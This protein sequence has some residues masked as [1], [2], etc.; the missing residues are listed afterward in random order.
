ME[1][2]HQLELVGEQ[3]QQVPDGPVYR[4]PGYPCSSA[5]TPDT[6]A[7]VPLD[8]ASQ[9]SKDRGGE[10]V[11][12]TP[13]LPTLQAARFLEGPGPTTDAV[14]LWHSTS[15]PLADQGAACCSGRAGLPKQL[16]RSDAQ[17]QRPCHRFNIIEG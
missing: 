1:P 17:L 8:G 16:H 11:R 12:L 7:G 5:E 6:K 10:A 3:A 4:R 15:A 13:V 9:Y 2:L 14:G